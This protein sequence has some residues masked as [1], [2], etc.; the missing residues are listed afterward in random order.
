MKNEIVRT[1]IDSS[2]KAQVEAIL[3]QLGLTPSAAITLF[4]K[5]I[6]LSRGLPFEVRIPAAATQAA[7]DD[8]RLGRNLESYESEQELFAAMKACAC[9]KPKPPRSSKKTAK[10]PGNAAGASKTCN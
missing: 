9:E 10:Q 3:A 1:R 4:Y 5:Q 6:I 7:I 2:V 8:A